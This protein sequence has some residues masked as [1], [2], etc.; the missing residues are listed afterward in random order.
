[1]IVITR[2]REAILNIIKTSCA[3][4]TAEELLCEAKKAIPDISRATVYN[5]LHYLEN[6]KLIRRISG[7]DGKDRYDKSFIPH[8]HLICTACGR[9][10]DLDLP[11]LE[12][13]L[14]R[15]VGSTYDS[16]ELKVRYLCPE[17]SAASE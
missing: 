9:I 11:D 15:A 5:T 8:G 3:H 14:R 10:Q 7:D 1:M 16:Y 6:Q 17:C 13:K 12:K 2:Q 4:Y